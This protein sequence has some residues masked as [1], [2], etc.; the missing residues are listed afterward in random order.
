MGAQGVR[1]PEHATNEVRQPRGVATPSDS[2]LGNLRVGALGREG[3]QRMKRLALLLLALPSAVAAQDGTRSW[4]EARAGSELERYA[5]LAQL[6]GVAPLGHVGARPILSLPHPDSLHPWRARLLNPAKASWSFVRPRAELIG[7]SGIPWGMNDGP[8]WAGVGATVQANGGVRWQRGP[9]SAQLA[10]TLWWSQNADYALLPSAS[11]RNPL[12]DFS[13]GGIDLPQRLAVGAL[14]RVDPGESYVQISK[15]GIQA[16]VTTANEWWGPGV[17]SGPMLSPE[18]AGLPR[19]QVG[20]ASP[21][22][23]GI[24]QITGR[25]F[26]GRAM[27]SSIS[28]DTTSNAGR[29]LVMGLTGSFSPRG[30][31]ELEVGLTRMFHRRWRNGGPTLAEIRTLFDP[32]FKERLGLAP[33]DFAAGR[34][35]NQLAS[36]FGRL[37]IPGANLEL[38]A[39]YLR[40]DHSWD[41]QDFLQEPDHDSGVLFGWQKVLPRS[42]DRWWVVRGELVNARITHLDRIRSQTLF[43]SH[44][45]LVD[46]HTMRGQLLGSPFVRGGNGAE[47]AVERY[48]ATGRLSVRWQR[49][50]LDATFDEGR[51]YGAI[52]RLEASTLRY[53]ARGDLSLRVGIGQRVGV[54]SQY[55]QFAAHAAVGWQW[56]W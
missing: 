20:S 51:S 21:W 54:T 16:A 37:A 56:G 52:H 41:T 43:Y 13:T 42:A 9:F 10:P 32:F 6:T 44:V 24:G 45:P 35:D 36:I 17:A 5:R 11:T 12:A 30:L 1:G 15:F 38:Y 34:L 26:V 33:D 7:N 47:L 25:A 50:G 53:G 19:V 31:P 55:D 49:Q 14:G 4:G 46:G 2:H 39:E 27:R 40:E 48:D 28:K 8:I 22:N 29:R 18:A 3:Y 23:I